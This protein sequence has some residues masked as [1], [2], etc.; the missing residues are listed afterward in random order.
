MG[1]GGVTVIQG[2]PETRFEA[3]SEIDGLPQPA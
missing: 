2:T 1:A 3:E